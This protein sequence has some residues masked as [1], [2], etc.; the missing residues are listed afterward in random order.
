MRRTLVQTDVVG[1]VEREVEVLEDLREPEALHVVDEAAIGLVHVVNRG[2]CI[3]VRRLQV[4]LEA[5]VRGDGAVVV[6][7]V[8]RVTPGVEVGLEHL[9]THV[10]VFGAAEDEEAVLIVKRGLFGGRD[11]AGVVAVAGEVP[12]RL[13]ADA[14]TTC[15]KKSERVQQRKRRGDRRG[16]RIGVPAA[17]VQ[18]ESSVDD[19]LV[20]QQPA[21]H[22]PVTSREAREVRADV[23]NGPAVVPIGEICPGAHSRCLGTR[24]K[25]ITRMGENRTPYPQQRLDGRINGSRPIVREDI[26]IGVGETSILDEVLQVAVRSSAPSL[27]ES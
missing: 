12:K 18:L 25:N 14:G 5:L 27:F 23:P 9:R 20:V 2:E 1:V 17:L 15:P 16:A 22:N 10:V 19:R 8:A 26:F 21:A 11:R 6:L 3:D 7:G 24:V 13:R 4:S